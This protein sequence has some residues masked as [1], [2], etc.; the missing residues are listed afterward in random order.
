MKLCLAEN[1]SSTHSA[2]SSS[3][4]HDRHEALLRRHMATHIPSSSVIITTAA[5]HPS[6]PDELDLA[7]GAASTAVVGD[8]VAGAE[9]DGLA[10]VGVLDGPAVGVAVGA[11]VAMAAVG[12]VLGLDFGLGCGA[13][14]TRGVAPG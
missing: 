5:T 6:R 7:V 1:Q 8:V 12:F 10:G 4:C 13:A 9:A 2:E 3:S 14:A 11:V